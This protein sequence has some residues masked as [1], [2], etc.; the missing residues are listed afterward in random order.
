MKQKQRILKIAISLGIVTTILFGI[1]TNVASNSETTTDTETQEYISPNIVPESESEP[2]AV[3]KFSVYAPTTSNK[4]VRDYAYKEVCR[5]FGCEQWD[6][7]HYLWGNESGWEPGRLN[8]S[9]FACGIPQSLPCTKIYSEFWGMERAW[10]DGK[11]YIKNPD[12]KREIDWGLQYILGRYKTPSYAWYFWN[13]IAPT[14]DLNEDGIADGY[15]Y[16]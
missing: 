15:H 7:V 9:S 10:K 13:H 8:K 1:A 6:Y 4:E 11:L 3:V 16:Y 2:K 14:V 5:I 12:Y